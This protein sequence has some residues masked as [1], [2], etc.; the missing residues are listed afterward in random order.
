[1]KRII[2]IFCLCLL[3]ALSAGPGAAQTPTPDDPQFDGA[4]LLDLIAPPAPDADDD[5]ARGDKLLD[6][7]RRFQ[8]ARIQGLDKLRAALP[9]PADRQFLEDWLFFEQCRFVAVF[10]ELGKR[11]VD[12]MASA[13]IRQTA[14]K[15]TETAQDLAARLAQEK[16]DFLL[17]HLAK[18]PNL[19]AALLRKPEPE[20]CV[21][22]SCGHPTELFELNGYYESAQKDITDEQGREKLRAIYENG[23]NGY[24]AYLYQRHDA[25]R[26]LKALRDLPGEAARAAADRLAVFTRD[27]QAKQRLEGLERQFF[28]RYLQ[29]FYE[30]KFYIALYNFD[31]KTTKAEL[32]EFPKAPWPPGLCAKHPEFLRP[33][34]A[35]KCREAGFGATAA[36][37]SAD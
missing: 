33:E 14:R 11:G 27:G 6:Y 31:G 4:A 3:S 17:D 22:D 37:P 23:M 18:N 34:I 15:N 24:W 26:T 30:A 32:G 13:T 35:K 5:P 36:S 16:A 10:L 2:S 12:L 7:A 21:G 19:D 28:S 29:E 1:M 25:E 8:E 20:P 9:E